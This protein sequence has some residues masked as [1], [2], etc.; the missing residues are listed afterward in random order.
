MENKTKE[1]A[2][3]SRFLWLFPLLALVFLCAVAGLYTYRY[4]QRFLPGTSIAGVDCSSMTAQ[5]AAQALK[6][7]AA[8]GSVTLGDSSGAQVAALPM[9]AFLDE[10]SLEET[11]YS[12]YARQ[13]ESSGLFDW[14]MPGKHPYPVSFFR[15]VTG[16]EAAAALEAALYSDQPLIAPVSAKVRLTDEGYEVIPEEPGNAVDMKACSAA[17]AQG[18]RS[19]KTIW[20]APAAIIADRAFIRPPVT[21]DSPEI[22]AVTDELDSYFLLPVTLDFGDGEAYTLSPGEIR[23]VCDVTI[24]RG[25][26]KCIPDPALVRA[27]TDELVDLYGY[28]GVYAKFRHVEDARDYVYYRVGDNG[29]I[30]DRDA[31]ADQVCSA[32]TAREGAVVTPSYDYTWYWKGFYARSRVPDTF[33]EISLD[34]QYLWAFKDGQLVAETPVVTG[35][36]AERCDTRRGCFRIAYKEADV[37]LRGPTWNDHVD[38]WMP[39]DGEIGLHDSSWRSVYGGDIYLTDGSHGCVNTPL[40]AMRKIYRSFKSNDFVIVY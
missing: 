13:K 35:N 3:L 38:Y 40:E 26:V 4:Q 12:V 28:D 19:L 8:E 31:L 1:K 11:A 39:F 22:K 37:I 9:S 14:L 32:L 18:L 7:A 36:I 20:P 33:I 29:W 30:L 23:S 27:F 6:S 10:T 5:E 16:E 21:A 17:L 24:R 15:N 34:N 2:N 25:N